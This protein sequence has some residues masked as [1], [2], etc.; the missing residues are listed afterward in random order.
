M[1][2]AYDGVH[3]TPGMPPA[4][5]LDS[6]I[7]SK[8]TAGIALDPGLMGD[9]SKD[10]MFAAVMDS[11]M[12]LTGALVAGPQ[13]AAYGSVAAW[14]AAGSAYFGYY[15]V[16]EVL[17]RNTLGKWIM[18]LRIRQVFGERCTRWQ[19]VV[20]SLFRVLEVNPIFF[21]DLP[22]GISIFC[23]K[24]RQRIG[25]LVAGTVVVRRSDLT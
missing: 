12:A 18:G 5:R 25:D 6:G 9:M 16:S 22:A 23:T 3:V 20:R 13:L 10:R 8:I 17:F 2:R 14:A 21:G 7:D 24:R 11:F 19:L 4:A 15:F 1:E